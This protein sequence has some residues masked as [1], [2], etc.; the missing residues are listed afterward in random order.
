MMEF[1]QAYAN[2]LADAMFWPL[3]GLTALAISISAHAFWVRERHNYGSEQNTDA[4]WR[5]HAAAQGSILLWIAYLILGA[6]PQPNF[7]VKET[8]VEVAAEPV[9]PVVIN[10]VVTYAEAVGA[11]MDATFTSDGDRM[12]GALKQ[13]MCSQQ[14]LLLVRPDL[15]V[16][17]LLHFRVDPYAETYHLCQQNYGTS[18]ALTPER[19]VEVEKEEAQLCHEQAMEVRRSVGLSVET[20]KPV[21]KPREAVE[22]LDHV[23]HQGT[24]VKETTP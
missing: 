16:Y 13:Q 12:S 15:N 6:V 24:P 4:R 9:E 11:C 22:V 1:L 3:I 20:S 7:M 17:K 19:Y 14:G 2:N 21:K 18:N 8:I 5:T 10:K 23:V